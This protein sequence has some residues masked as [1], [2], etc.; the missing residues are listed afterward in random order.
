[1]LISFRCVQSTRKVGRPKGA[2]DC[3]PRSRT[4]PLARK[5]IDSMSKKFLHIPSFETVKTG[6]DGAADA[7]IS[8]RIHENRF[9]QALPSSVEKSIGTSISEDSGMEWMGTTMPSIETSISEDSGMEWMETTVFTH[10]SP[11]PFHE[12]WPY[13][14]C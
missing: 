9:L 6:S 10:D 3:K 13:W 1:M 7:R 8:A 4:Q 12:D 11:D 2:R 14:S 5:Q